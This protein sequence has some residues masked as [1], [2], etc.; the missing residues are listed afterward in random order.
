VNYELPFTHAVQRAIAI[1]LF[2]LGIADNVQADNC[3]SFVQDTT[4]AKI[5]LQIHNTAVIK[6]YLADIKECGAPLGEGTLPP[7]DK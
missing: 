3:E 7:S 2:T 5:V 1:T 4:D 6:S